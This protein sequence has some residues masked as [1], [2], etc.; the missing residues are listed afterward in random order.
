MNDV[1]PPTTTRFIIFY[2][3]FFIFYF[4]YLYGRVWGQ[5]YR[6]EW[7]TISISFFISSQYG[8]QNEIKSK[9]F[10]KVLS[11]LSYG[12]MGVLSHYAINIHLLFIS[13]ISRERA[14]TSRNVLHG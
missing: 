14:S 8:G 3:L 4:M 12:C 5:L 13:R 9:I 7:T 10:L 6:T 1:W 11:V 2:F